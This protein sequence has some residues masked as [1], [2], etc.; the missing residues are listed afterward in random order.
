MS[1]LNDTIPQ[2]EFTDRKT[3]LVVL[4]VLQIVLGAFCALALPMMIIGMVAS[5]VTGNQA[6]E[7]MNLKQMIPAIIMYALA[8][9]WFIWVGIGSVKA[10]RW[11]R[12]LIL[13]TSWFW[14]IGGTLGFLIMLLLI[15]SL[16][17]NDHMPQSAAAVFRFV[18][19]AFMVVFFIGLPGLFVLFYR[20]RDVKATCEHYDPQTRWTDKCPLPVLGLSLF[21]FWSAVSV[22]KAGFINWTFPFFGTVLSGITGAA[23]TVAICLLLV[24]IAWGLYR[25]DIKA[26]WTSLLVNC[27][28]P[29]SSFITFSLVSTET[30]YENAGMTAQQMETIKQT[31]VLSNPMMRWPMLLWTAAIVAYLFYI[32]KYFVNNS[33]QDM[34]EAGNV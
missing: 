19:V 23:V 25:L 16:F 13:V 8:A 24:W 4:G 18:M 6:A 2:M 15:P 1:E 11:A 31:D 5:A 9:T 28:M 17:S 14:L 33:A 12:A 7:G 21:C 3:R 27:G 30:Y 26:W 29:I 32:R 20:G 34:V 22:P 10:R